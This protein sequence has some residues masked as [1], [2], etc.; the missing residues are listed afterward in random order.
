[1]A[2]KLEQQLEQNTRQFINNTSKNK[3]DSKKKVASISKI[4]DWFPEDFSK[5][6][7]SVQKFLAN[8]IEDTEVAAMLAENMF[9]LKYLKY[10]WSLNG[11]PVK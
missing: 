1:M 3:F 4:F 8:Y 10:D 9:R 6:S 11:T 7:G 2:D 5:H